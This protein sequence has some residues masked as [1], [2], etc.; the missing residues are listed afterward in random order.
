LPHSF[1]LAEYPFW[2][3]TIVPCNQKKHLSQW[4]L[5]TDPKKS[6]FWVQFFNENSGAFVNF[7]KTVPFDP[8]DAR[9]YA[10][11]SKSNLFEKQRIA[12]DMATQDFYRM[13][14][15]VERPVGAFGAVEMPPE[16]AAAGAT[17]G[18]AEQREKRKRADEGD[19]GDA[20]SRPRA[21][22]GRVA[23]DTDDEANDAEDADDVDGGADGRG[24]DSEQDAEDGDD[25]T[26]DD[27]VLVPLSLPEVK[28]RG[29]VK[30]IA[31]K[32]KAPKSDPLRAP[33]SRATATSTGRY[34]SLQRANKKL[35]VDLRAQSEALEQ[36]DARV[37]DL[38]RRVRK[39]KAK[40]SANEKVRITL[41][42]VPP[43]LP[44]DL[45]P[46]SERA[47]R[48][49]GG[50]ELAVLLSGCSK[51]FEEYEGVVLSAMKA[52]EALTEEAKRAVSA[53]QPRFDALRDATEAVLACELKVADALRTL[54]RAKLSA[55]DI[56][57]CKAGRT[58][59]RIARR[60]SAN[61]ALLSG[62]AGAVN[63]CWV[64]LVVKSV[65]SGELQKVATGVEAG[66]GAKA[67]TA[68]EAGGQAE[69]GV[70]AE[71]GDQVEAD[72]EAAACSEASAANGTAP[73]DGV[74][75]GR[76][77]EFVQ[78]RGDAAG[79]DGAVGPVDGDD[80]GDAIAKADVKGD[81]VDADVVEGNVAS[82][83]EE[84]GGDAAD[85]TG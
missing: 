13:N 19:P 47:T 78:S 33:R 64:D 67:V 83:F 72:G 40:L 3:A 31:A 28:K 1:G 54:Y 51:K 38:E 65:S 63:S 4:R 52:D 56:A 55:T 11:H 30:R 42:D 15:D 20:A 12:I 66:S 77:A 71:A 39:L 8:L 53:V 49:M 37:V 68:V 7:D 43:D 62:L 9:K 35:R 79:E 25:S 84:K 5:G 22:K 76:P 17:D 6:K 80:A 10:V 21:K 59:K 50:D 26:G 73:P 48:E 14:P 23:S 60:A 32:K 2:P 24:L 82:K 18:K 61:S 29:S 58:V 46:E 74:A 41:P 45:P 69:A 70:K 57:D 36:S 85:R 44:A 34:L 75:N 16:P 27:D 81:A